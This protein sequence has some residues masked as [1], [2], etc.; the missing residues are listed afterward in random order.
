[1]STGLVSVYTVV[2]FTFVS[3]VSLVIVNVSS[4]VKSNTSSLNM[5]LLFIMPLVSINSVVII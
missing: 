3:H 5:N 1:M 4:V 2:T